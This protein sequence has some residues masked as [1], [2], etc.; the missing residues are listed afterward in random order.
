MSVN[1]LQL[2]VWVW[3]LQDFLRWR[4]PIESVV[5]M[6]GKYWNSLGSALLSLETSI[7]VQAS[8]ILINVTLR[9]SMFVFWICCCYCRCFWVQRVIY[10][11]IEERSIDFTIFYANLRGWWCDF[12]VWCGWYC[13]HSLGSDCCSLIEVCL[14][15]CNQMVWLAWD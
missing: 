14:C 10:H 4:H 7:L 15:L 8:V 5:E 2:R 12:K 6:S 9:L 13:G 1:G 11:K 3:T